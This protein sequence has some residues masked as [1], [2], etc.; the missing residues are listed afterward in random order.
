[1][2]IKNPCVKESFDRRTIQIT[3]YV[4]RAD[5]EFAIK[6]QRKLSTLT[7]A[8]AQT[9]PREGYVGLLVHVDDDRVL[10]EECK[11]NTPL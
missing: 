7:F 5:L 1:M 2:M 6:Q 9:E 10:S 11:N 4:R 3:V 8:P